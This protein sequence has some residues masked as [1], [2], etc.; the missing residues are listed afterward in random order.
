MA[1]LRPAFAGLALSL[2]LATTTLA[3]GVRADC[4]SI[5]ST[6]IDSDLLWPTAGTTTFFSVGSARTLDGGRFG[7]GIATDLQRKPLV[8]RKN[9][10]GPA[11]DVGVPGIGTQVVST[12]LFSYGVTDRFEVDVATPLTLFQNGTG[13][14]SVTGGSSSDLSRGVTDVPNNAVRDVRIGAAY[15]IAP[16]PR[17]YGGHGVGL[18]ARFD[19][20]LPTGDDEAFAGDRGVVA[21]PALLLENRIGPVVMGAHAGARIRS[22]TQFFD[23]TVGSQ[24]YLGLGFGYSLDKRETITLTAEGFALPTLVENG[25]SPLQWL[26]GVRWSGLWG[27]DLVLHAGG[28]GGFRS[29]ERAE[30]LEPSYRFVFDIRYAPIS[31]DR[32]GDGIPDRDDK[33]PDVKEDKDGF[34]DTDGC[35]DP[36]NDKDGIPDNLDKCPSQ[37]EDIDGFQDDDGCPEPDRDGDGIKDVVDKC[38][39]QAEDKNGYQD[40]DGCP[41]GGPPKLT[42]KCANGTM[43]APETACDSDLDGIPDDKEVCPLAAEDKDGIVDD[44]GCPEKDADEDGV[45]DQNDKCPLEPETIDGKDDDDGCPEAGAHS[46]VTFVDGVIEVEKPIK[47]GAGSALVTKPMKAQIAMIA[48]RVQGLVDRGVEKIG[49]EAWADTAGENKANEALAMKRAE[50]LA[51]ALVAAGVPEGLIK[52]RVG[53]LADPPK[54]AKPNW[55]ITVR[56]KRKAPL[57]APKP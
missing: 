32:D 31:L 16:L 20:S 22:K 57:G 40:D 27:G 34:E 2:F 23:R 51:A 4:D 39:D 10:A 37:A 36:D 25:P 21:V 48:Q 49:I 30:L 17:D 7:F 54:G 35:P 18:S 8:L 12:F 43:V 53:D 13:V 29:A 52:P 14:S 47:F 46:L 24:G 26:A 33:C 5:A 28:G 11:G 1:L 42:K 41:E 45:G 3:P 44:D 38:P 9:A 6:C 19:L 56:T 55:L 15:A 50:A